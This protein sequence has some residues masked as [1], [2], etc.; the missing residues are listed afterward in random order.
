MYATDWGGKELALYCFFSSP[1]RLSA[2]VIGVFLPS[3]AFSIVLLYRRSLQA[4]LK[5]SPPF[6]ISF[7]NSMR[8]SCRFS[9]FAIVWGEGREL[10]SLLCFL[11]I[12][13]CVLCAVYSVYSAH[14]TLYSVLCSAPLRLRFL[15]FSS[16]A[17]ETR[18][19]KLETR[20]GRFGKREDF[21]FY[22]RS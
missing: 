18:N 2:A 7:G 10:V 17:R 6:Q 20:D 19:S 9:A 21:G 16:S 11:C 4:A 12:L 13:R 14:C 22:R 5:G 8:C 15:L 1:P 3:T